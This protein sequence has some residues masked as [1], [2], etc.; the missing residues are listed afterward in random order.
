MILRLL[1][2]ASIFPALL[3]RAEPTPSPAS[4]PP[5]D[6][7]PAPAFRARLFDLAGALGNEGFKVRD[8][9]WVGRLEGGKP[10]RL[11]LN[12]FA[13]NQYWLCAAVPEDARGV[14][15][16]VHDAAGKPV[17][18]LSHQQPGLIAAGLTAE[19]T[20]PYFVELLAP[21][22]QSPDFCFTYLFK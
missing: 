3:V 18:V 10:R 14:K 12:L 9:C 7:A 21:A 6:P 15:I 4:T 8:G 22:G 11:A 5:G 16:S 19:T 13:G 2:L 20:G 1:M 17:T